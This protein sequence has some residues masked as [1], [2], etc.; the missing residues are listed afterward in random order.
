MT[1]KT[2]RERLVTLFT[3]QGFTQVNAFVPTEVQGTDK[4][5]NIYSSASSQDRMSGD[6]RNDFYVFN[7]DV[8]IKRTN[9]VTCEDSLDNLREVVNTVIANNVSDSTWNHIEL[10]NE[11]ECLFAE[12]SGVHYRMERFKLNVKETR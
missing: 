7:L 9:S 6:M 3:N 11:S 12:I 8:L 10:L 1:R 5:L 2:V 4:V